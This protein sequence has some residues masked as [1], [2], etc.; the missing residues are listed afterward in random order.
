MET[1]TMDEKIKEEIAM[2]KFSDFL[3]RWPFVWLVIP[4]GILLVSSGP[5]LSAVDQWITRMTGME[6]MIPL[7]SLT[8]LIM[9]VF[10]WMA[11][12]DLTFGMLKFNLRWLFDYYLNDNK[13]KEDFEEQ[14][15][16]F[17]LWYL[18]AWCALLILSFTIIVAQV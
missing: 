13:C 8:I 9:G 6:G 2:K 12:A 4:L 1:S 14:T 3:K 5:L 15:G 7:S 17:R 16:S 10:A 18:F 11:S